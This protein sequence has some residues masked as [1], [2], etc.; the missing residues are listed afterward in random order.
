MTGMPER[1]ELDVPIGDCDLPAARG[2]YRVGG[3]LVVLLD[4]ERVARVRTARRADSPRRAPAE[5]R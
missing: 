2:T 5:A 1:I 3:R 4:L